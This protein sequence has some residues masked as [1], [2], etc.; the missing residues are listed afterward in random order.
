M[1]RRPFFLL[2]LACLAALFVAVNALG[3]LWLK[4][5]R[6][7]LTE[8]RLYTLSQGARDI[9]DRLS[10]PVDVTFFY[11]RD[12]A[13]NYQQIRGYGARVRE[14]LQAYAARSG[15]MIR[16]EIVDPAPYSVEE[17]RAIAAGMEAAPTDAGDPLYFGLSARN[18]V[19]ERAVIA[20]FSPEREP[21][22]EYELARVFSELESP[23]EVKVALL[24][25]LPLET[26]PQGGAA[27]LSN[28]AQGLFAFR[29]MISA[30]DL[31]ILDGDFAE[32][33]DDADVLVLAHPG[34]LEDDQLYAIDQ[35]VL[36]HG[37]ALVFLD[38]YSRL[39]LTP[40]PTGMPPLDAQRFSDL[41]P[42]IE[43]WGVAFDPETVVL[44]PDNALRAAFLEDG[45]RVERDYPL[46]LE[47]RPDAMDPDDLAT[48]PLKRGLH[49]IA[50]GRLDPVEGAATDFTPLARTSP[51][52]GVADA[53]QTG[54]DPT[55]D[56]LMA[57]FR[58]AGGPMTLIA[59]VSGA[60]AS[61]FPAGAP[62]GVSPDAD[63][64]TSGD[65]EII[66][67]A[68]SDLFDDGF[69]VADDGLFGQSTF[70]DNAA[71][72]LNAI[73]LLAG[74][75][76]LISLRSRPSSARPM[77]RVE[78]LRAA[79]EMRYFEEQ[80]S[81]EAELA[82]AESRLQ[83]LEAAGKVSTAFSDAASQEESDEAERARA[84]IFD[85]RARLR[86]VQRNFRADVERLE[87]W[88]IFL[89]VWLT[90]ILV[91]AFGVWVFVARRRAFA[92]R[93]S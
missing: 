20:F 29:E 52:A 9:V 31:D 24:T 43:A 11:S 44:D 25:G 42:L 23:A 38:P 58:P 85:T 54:G 89:N 61:A 76:A 73:D 10:E 86:D 90:P 6:L 3:G 53:M 71:F 2:A 22:L 15:G 64:L 26:G 79:A 47:V 57:G 72:V 27:L 36:R 28:K 32:I 5:V 14:T 91:A 66:L 59:R 48:A 88:L 78:A 33:P 18:A 84:A 87:A 68:D 77:K 50:A 19:D 49:L 16:L 7:D 82:A 92:G 37:R 35:W 46:W 81:L 55:P 70:M 41:G 63:A 93:G 51:A 40:G 30:F 34:P 80:S 12:L 17:D 83:E 75:A 56:E 62:D 13:Q 74:D 60:A 67:T 1:R 4:R 69:Y 45:R 65:V 21:F 8:D 39:A